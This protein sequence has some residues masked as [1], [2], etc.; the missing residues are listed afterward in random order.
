VKIDVHAHFYPKRYLAALLRLTEGDSSPWTL[1]VRKL[2]VTKIAPDRRMVEIEAHLED[3]DRAGVDLQVLSP[4]IPHPYFDDQPLAVELAKVSND[5]L[6]EVCARYPA[7]FKGF[8][9]L[10]LPHAEAALAELARAINSLG[11]H[12]VV[13]GANVKGRHLDDESFLP[14]YREINRRKLTIFLHPMIPPGQEE[15]A[16]YDLSAAVGFHLDT[17]LATLRLVYRGV[18][19]ENPD[20]NFIVPHLGAMIP[21]VWDRINSSY[22][23][24]PEA[25]LHVKRPPAEYL[26]R[27]YYDSV[28][29]HPA[30]WRCALETVGVDRIVYGSDYPLPIG[31]MERGIALVDALDITPERREMIYSGTAARLLR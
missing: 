12:G 5:A 11:L 23:T 3:M 27:L 15:M 19:E 28:N 14:V 9:V 2:L 8:A 20:L 21:Y 13:L 6:A 4:T 24:R 22:R 1:G 25:Q 31:S 26:T 17:T 16:D 29:F 10:P 18:F 30:A 7:R